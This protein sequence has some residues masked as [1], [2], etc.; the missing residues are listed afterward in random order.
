MEAKKRK[1]DQ[2]GGHD[3][4][5]YEEQVAEEPAIVSWRSGSRALSCGAQAL[6]SG[7][8]RRWAN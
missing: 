7:E 6:V 5:V 4:K 8:T 3:E 1:Y 2:R